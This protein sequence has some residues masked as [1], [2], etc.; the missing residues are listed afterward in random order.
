MKKI[1]FSVL[2]SVLLAFTGGCT[3][4]KVNIGEE[5]QPLQEKVIAGQGRDK[6]LVL[7][8]S[9]VIMSGEQ[10]ML[11][12]E[13]KKP[14]LIARVREALDRARHDRRVKAVVLRINSPGGG[15]TASDILYH[16]LKKFKQETGV[17]IV[18]HIMDIGASGAYYAALAADVI[19]AQPTSVTGSI[20][21]IMYRVDATGLMQKV[22]LQAVEI[23]S[24]EK[25]GIGSPFRPVTD[26]ERKIF[27]GFVDSLYTRF[28]GL[29]AEERRLTPEDVKKIADGR[30]YTS[31][32]AQANGLIDQIGYLEDAVELAK[33]RAHLPEARVVTYFRPGDYR[34]N[35]YSM[36]LINVDLGDLADPGTKFLYLWW[37]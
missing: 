3:F 30:I 33:K 17:T 12:T 20:G 9:G 7:D 11:L 34:A 36:N 26:D 37:P 27:Q 18:A 8:I 6:V 35:I 10:G 22:G 5:V 16:E 19:T 2:V 14:G 25:K 15:V 21:V 4:L 31:K 1:I 28:T 29:V 23:A 32:E 13:R 24:A